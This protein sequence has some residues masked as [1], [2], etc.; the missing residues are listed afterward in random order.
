MQEKQLS[1]C[2]SDGEL[3]DEELESVVG[4]KNKSGDKETKTVTYNVDGETTTYTD[5]DTHYLGV[6]F[7][8]SDRRIKTDIQV[9][10]Y[11]EDLNLPLYS[12]KY[13]NGDPTRYVG[14]IAQDLLSC[15]NTAH[16][17]YI[18][19]SGVFAGYYA[20]NYESLGLRMIAE[21]EWNIKRRS[22]IKAAALSL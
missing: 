2:T 21:V 4:G 9:V 12:W 7:G 8:G 16:A 5:K 10:G 11:L 3:S 20:V 15:P 1:F 13:R 19:D 22:T 18:K 6:G 14:L 17:V